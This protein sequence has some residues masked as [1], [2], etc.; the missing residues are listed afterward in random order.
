MKQK[1]TPAAL[2]ERRSPTGGSTAACLRLSIRARPASSSHSRVARACQRARGMLS[3]CASSAG[4]SGVAGR[5]AGEAAPAHLRCW[6]AAPPKAAATALCVDA[7]LPAASK[8]TSAPGPASARKARPPRH[9]QDAAHGAPS[10]PEGTS[11]ADKEIEVL[12]LSYDRPRCHA[13]GQAVHTCEP[14]L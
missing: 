14:C 13:R 4:R 10:P 2:W 3:S 1:V 11:G 5:S 12:T 9:R 8:A 7:K 6:L